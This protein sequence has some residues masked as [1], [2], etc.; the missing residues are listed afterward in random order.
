MNVEAEKIKNF[1][2]RDMWT[3]GTSGA[4]VKLPS[5]PFDE[6]RC[7]RDIFDHKASYYVADGK[8]LKHLRKDGRYSSWILYPKYIGT[9]R[10]GDELYKFID[11]AG[12]TVKLVTDNVRTPTSM[13]SNKHRENLS[14]KYS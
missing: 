8:L 2:K 11:A 6:K 5:K 14:L 4:V 13:I 7:V 1:T 9:S 10:D 12:N 3:Y